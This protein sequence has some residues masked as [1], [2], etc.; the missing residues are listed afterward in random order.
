LLRC[1]GVAKTIEARK[2][3]QRARGSWE[4]HA[5][6]ARARDPPAAA[7]LLFRGSY[8]FRQNGAHGSGARNGVRPHFR[9]KKASVPG[10][11][12]CKIGGGVEFS[13]YS[14]RLHFTSAASCRIS[15][16]DR[17]AG[18]SAGISLA[19]VFSPVINRCWT[20]DASRASSVFADPA[21][22]SIASIVL[23]WRR[24]VIRARLLARSETTLPQRRRPRWLG[25]RAHRPARDARR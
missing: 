24:C 19:Q 10:E 11:G 1:L 16:T 25:R 18:A 2:R 8:V 9:A 14:L 6:A 17:A 13:L 23:N 4:P 21:S 22:I 12:S 20:T 15:A 7:W 3:S 5:A